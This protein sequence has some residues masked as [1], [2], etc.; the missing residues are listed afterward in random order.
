MLYNLFPL[1]VLL[2]LDALPKGNK[3]GTLNVL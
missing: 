2:I 1:N 3:Y